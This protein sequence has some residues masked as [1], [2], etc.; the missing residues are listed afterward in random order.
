MIIET[1]YNIS[2]K[3]WVVWQRGSVFVITDRRLAI[4]GFSVMKVNRS[5][6]WYTEE[7]LFGC[8]GS[9]LRDWYNEDDMFLCKA[10]AQTERDKRNAN[11]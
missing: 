7:Y 2:D 1:K 9:P 3:F 11:D 4:R 10:N 5:D 8:P 6:N